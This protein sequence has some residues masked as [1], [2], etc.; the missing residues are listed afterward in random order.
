MEFTCKRN[1]EGP[2]L[3][4]LRT[5]KTLNIT[6]FEC[7]SVALVIRQAKRMRHIVISGLTR[8]AIFFHIKKAARFSG[9]RVFNVKYVLV[10]SLTSV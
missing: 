10:M 1:I 9:K 5:G 7:T 8:S 6:Y 2:S 4:Y 3:N